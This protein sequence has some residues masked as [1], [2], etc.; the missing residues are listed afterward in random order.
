VGQTRHWAGEF[1]LPHIVVTDS[2]ETSTSAIARITVIQ[3]FDSNGKFSAVDA[4]GG[5]QGMDIN[6]RDELW[7]ITHR[8]N[9][10][11]VTYDTLRADMRID[12]STARSWAP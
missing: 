7:I 8:N 3:I 4:P 5:Q 12:V 2:Q 10:E 9:I 11:N 6:S 1:D